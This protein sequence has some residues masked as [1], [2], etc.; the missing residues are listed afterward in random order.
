MSLHQDLKRAARCLALLALC[1][2]VACSGGE[3]K[4]TPLTRAPEEPTRDIQQL[5]THPDGSLTSTPS[6]SPSQPIWFTLRGNDS[7]AGIH[8]EPVITAVMILPEGW[9]PDSE[10]FA[11]WTFTERQSLVDFSFP[12]GKLNFLFVK[13][14]LICTYPDLLSYSP[15]IQQ[16]Y[17]RE[18]NSLLVFGDNTKMIGTPCKDDFTTTH[19]T[20]DP[21]NRFP[22]RS[23]SPNGQYRAKTEFYL[24]KNPL[25]AR[26]SI[27]D[28]QTGHVVLDVEWKF[29]ETEG[30]GLADHWVTEEKYLISVTYD[31]GPLLID[32]K[33]GAVQVAPE[34]FNRP[35]EVNCV[36]QTNFC[37]TWLASEG[38]MVAARDSYHVVLYGWGMVSNFPQVELYHSESNETE[39]I[40]AYFFHS[41]SPDGRWMY[42]YNEEFDRYKRIPYIITGLR[43]V[44]PPGSPGYFLLKADLSPFNNPWSPD[45]KLVAIKTAGGIYVY[46]LP[47]VNLVGLWE[48]GDYES[49]QGSWSP[50]G[51]YFAVGSSIPK[52]SGIEALFLLKIP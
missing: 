39:A 12:P 30:L 51:R 6:R 29:V 16:V 47:E 1:L 21:V 25:L 13:T 32:V 42:V 50:D 4:G 7:I 15:S 18:D 23:I 22:E 28:V 26:T 17:W 45:S 34:L 43:P 48:L 35:V 9:S 11:F 10:V 46:S 19:E 27:I 14:G 3:E 41:F 36:A 8:I 38:S 44:D 37:E 2:S 20:V 24:P 33:Q 5:P 31:Q 52:P 40:P 49:I